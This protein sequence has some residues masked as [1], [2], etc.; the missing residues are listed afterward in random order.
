M[1]IFT[2]AV[3]AETNAHQQQNGPTVR[4]S[5]HDLLPSREDEPGAATDMDESRKLKAK[6]KKGSHE[7]E[8]Q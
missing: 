2:V 1:A 4:Q 5:Y 8:R 3:F 7:E 6:R